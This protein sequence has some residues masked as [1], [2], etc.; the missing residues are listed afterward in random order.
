MCEGHSVHTTQH[1]NSSLY[2]F[3]V[4]AEAT[5]YTEEKVCSQR[6]GV[7]EMKIYTIQYWVVTKRGGHL[8]KRM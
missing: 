4:L 3:A 7:R 8:L 6:A 5:F 2:E 1:S